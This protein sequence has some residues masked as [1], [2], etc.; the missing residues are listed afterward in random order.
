MPRPRGVS[1]A[2]LGSRA[3]ARAADE[4]MVRDADSPLALRIFRLFMR[5][6]WTLD[7]IGGMPWYAL[8]LLLPIV[9]LVNAIGVAFQ[10]SR[11]IRHGSIHGPGSRS[12]EVLRTPDARFANIPDYP[13]E[14]HYWHYEGARLHYVDEGAGQGDEV[15]LMLHGEPTWSFLYRKVVPQL[16]AKGYRVI[17]PDALGMGKSDKP[18]CPYAYSFPNHVAAVAALCE[19]LGLGPAT[20]TLTLVLHDWGGTYGQC[21]MPL[22]QPQRLVLLNTIPGPADLPRCGHHWH[23]DTMFAIWSASVRTVGRDFDVRNAMRALIF[24]SGSSDQVEPAVLTGYDA[25]FPGPE[26]KGLAMTWP[27]IY[28]GLHLR[29]PKVFTPLLAAQEEVAKS[30]E[31]PV[32]VAMGAGDPLFNPDHMVPRIR[33]WLGKASSVERVDIQNASHFVSEAQPDAVAAAIGDFIQKHAS[34]VDQTVR[35]N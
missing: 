14:P 20:C 7:V 35:Q 4:R 13:F 15:V 34:V 16:V 32:L 8:P 12:D 28:A 23:L 5:N 30:Y 1:A 21:A 26:F 10:L 6:L 29:N 11:L 18:R 33:E 17:C 25:P 9:I 2:K 22:V 27:L 19:H 3:A 31:G 24:P